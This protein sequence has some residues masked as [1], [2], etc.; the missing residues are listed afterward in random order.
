MMTDF[1]FSIHKAMEELTMGNIKFRTYDL[2][3]HKQG[4]IK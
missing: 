1:S 3:G 4:E 2:G